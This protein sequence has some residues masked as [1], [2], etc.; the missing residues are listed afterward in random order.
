MNRHAPAATT[1]KGFDDPTLLAGRPW[2]TYL[3][4][5][6]LVAAL[7]TDIGTFR[8]ALDFAIPLSGET[9]IDLIV[10]GFAGIAVF[11]CHSAGV[12]LRERGAGTA[13]IRAW[14]AGICVTV[15]LLLGATAYLARVYAAAP[16]PNGGGG[17]VIDQ[18]GGAPPPP[19]PAAP[20]HDFFNITALMFL[21]LYVGTGLVAIVGSYLTHNPARG[22][23]VRTKWA[24]VR[25]NRRL[26][27]AVL[28]F[29]VAEGTRRLYELT[30]Q[31]AAAVLQQEET[32]R[33]KFAEALK[34]HARLI[35]AQHAKD[36]ALTD[37]LFVEDDPSPA[38]E[39]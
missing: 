2:G 35:M 20:V 22:A 9:T 37:A 32:R 25:A 12:M 6:A 30:S 15:W 29:E 7:A 27:K 8:Q 34:Q 26:A 28:R 19:M 21:V 36:P 5:L 23:F 13:W 16:A 24:L 33:R 4:G 39:R 31:S 10:C 18:P 38:P 14:P 11:L 1:G 3:Y 17:V